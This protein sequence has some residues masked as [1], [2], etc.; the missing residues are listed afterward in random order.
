MFSVVD[1]E[2]AFGGG[3]APEFT[4]AS[5]GILVS[6]MGTADAV[7]RF[8]QTSEPPVIGTVR[9]EGLVIDFRTVLEED[10]AALARACQKLQQTFESA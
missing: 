10:E 8:F 5:A 3:S 2:S 1:C 9:E 6:P 4:F 7:A